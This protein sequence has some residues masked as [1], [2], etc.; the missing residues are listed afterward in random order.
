LRSLCH[1]ENSD[2]QQADIH[3]GRGSSAFLGEGYFDGSGSAEGS[4]PAEFKTA[5]SRS[6]V[7]EAAGILA[8]MKSRLAAA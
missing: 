7:A 8:D 1:G 3:S 4:A 5:G 2:R 6:G